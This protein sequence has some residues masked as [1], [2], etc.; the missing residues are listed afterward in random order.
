MGRTL[1]VDDASP[2]A[3]ILAH[4]RPDDLLTNARLAW[5]EHAG[6]K[7]ALEPPEL[8]TH[9]ERYLLFY[10][11][12]DALPD[13]ACALTEH[14]TS[15]ESL[16]EVTRFFTNSCRELR[17]SGVLYDLEDM[18]TVTTQWDTF[19]AYVKHAR[20]RPV[21]SDK[22][23]LARAHAALGA[24]NI[25][26]KD[27]ACGAEAFE[28]R[29]RTSRYLILA[30]SHVPNIWESYHSQRREELD[31]NLRTFLQLPQ[32]SLVGVYD[33]AAPATILRPCTLKYALTFTSLSRS[34]RLFGEFTL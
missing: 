13:G 3:S 26:P 9:L 33:L 23:R 11:V 21:H 12:C 28:N 27:L 19:T 10:Q 5:Q 18:C 16:A 15:F 6:F 31:M 29:V 34:E 30:K 22:S 4:D 8:T 25:G 20:G 1:D 14:A 2:V 17:T 24:Q 7:G 32:S